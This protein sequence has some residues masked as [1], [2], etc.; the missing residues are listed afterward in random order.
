MGAVGGDLADRVNAHVVG[1]AV[2]LVG[3]AAREQD[4]QQGNQGKRFGG[5]NR[6]VFILI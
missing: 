4:D 3:G 5:S 2:L 6:H 1:G